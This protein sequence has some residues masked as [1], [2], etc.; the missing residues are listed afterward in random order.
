MTVQRSA[1]GAV[2]TVTGN[3]KEEIFHDLYFDRLNLAVLHLF[4]CG[5]VYRGL[6]RCLHPQAICQQRFRQQSAVS[7]LWFQCRTVRGLPSGADIPPFFSV[8]RRP[9]AGQ[10]GG[11]CHRN[12]NG[13]NLPEK[14]LGL[15]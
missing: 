12:G 7:C 2:C 9:S 3:T 14:A 13:E 6:L 10:P 5:L 4:L 1:A 11:I 15:L 8:F